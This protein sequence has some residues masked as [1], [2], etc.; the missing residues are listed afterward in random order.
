M[1]LSGDFGK[2][3]KLIRQMDQLGS[4]KPEL[5]RDLAA[6][7]LARVQ[8]GFEQGR[9]PDGST[10]A[11]LALRQGQPLLDTGRLR[12][13]ITY[14]LTSSGF[15]LGTAVAYASIHQYGGTIRAK[16]GGV[17]KWQV[18]GRWYTAKSVVIPARP[19]LP[20]GGRVSDE[21][22]RAFRDIAADWLHD[23]FKP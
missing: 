18:G 1:G 21:W 17:L 12:S 19:F 15:S 22:T 14:A 5:L 16:S 11:P 20:I 8:E 23:N 2:L 3:G 7:G 4:R 6:E 9:A 13:S 10:W